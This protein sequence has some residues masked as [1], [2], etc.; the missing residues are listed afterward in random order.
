MSSNEQFPLS[1]KTV[2]VLDR[3]GDL[4]VS[5]QQP[6]DV[7][8]ITKTRTLIPLA[9]IAKSLWTCAVE[10]AVEYCRIVWD[11][12][13]LGRL[14]RFVIGDGD[15]SRF[16][17][18][19]QEQSASQLMTAFAKI[20]PPS[21]NSRNKLDIVRAV[22]M[23][24]GTLC[25]P[26]E[27]QHMRRTDLDRTDREVANKGRVIVIT[28]LQG[29]SE[30]LKLE[31][32]LATTLNIVNK[33]ASQDDK[34]LPLDEVEMVLIHASP[35]SK[36]ISIP[37]TRRLH[38]SPLLAIETHKV[39]S[40]YFLS[41]KLC[42]LV[43][44]HYELAITTVTGIPMKEEQNANSSA[45]YDVE[46][47]HPQA[48][49]A[50]FLKD[51]DGKHDTNNP[52]KVTL[53]WCTPRTAP[54]QELQH[55]TAAHRI[56]PVD[57]NSRP[58]SCL[59]NFLLTGRA[60]MLELP[61]KSGQKLLSHMLASHGGEIYIHTLGTGR[62]ALEDPPS[63]SEGSG[64]RVTDYRITD[65]GLFMKEHLLVPYNTDSRNSHVHGTKVILNLVS[66]ESKGT[67]LALSS[68]AA[69]A[70]GL[71]SGRFAKGGLRKEEHYRALWTELEQLLRLYCST[72]EH[73]QVLDCLLDCRRGEAS[74]SGTPVLGA[75]GQSAASAAN[76]GTIGESS[77]NG[78]A[79]AGIKSESKPL[80]FV[81][82]PST[83]PSSPSE[84]QRPKKLRVAPDLLGKTS[85]LGLLKDN[86]RRKP[87]TSTWFGFNPETRKAILYQ[88]LKEKQLQQQ[89][90][91]VKEE[92]Q[93][94][95]IQQQ[96]QIAT[97]AGAQQQQQVQQQQVQQQI[98]Q[99][100]Q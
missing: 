36:E 84:D 18:L 88:N 54:T 79:T 39:T 85:L 7:D 30:I 35:G 57:I 52:S 49:H 56:T 53:K 41:E 71:G 43:Q 29:E 34:Q 9:P 24:L 89:Q 86:Q 91:A 3:G 1:H 76:P 2:I 58:S 78:G 87:A 46:L 69:V 63:I 62:S 95:Q 15:D 97:S 100:V 94:Q 22:E 28:Q 60:V 72:T 51:K 42:Q 92:Q 20:P 14:V 80:G 37:S 31:K 59:T 6:I 99:Q 55:C 13:P 19:W 65:F 23:A 11:I 73:E 64:G 90:Q 10:S 83:V 81:G 68:V 74:Q 12:Y 93:V 61:R 98:Q 66:M 50:D 25:E 8:Q 16:L 26:S 77:K 33:V 82:D 40:G 17:N 4:A 45:N 5:C 38:N 70:G 32:R 67:A 27:A 47:L 48:A 44:T 75:T 96:Q 21:A